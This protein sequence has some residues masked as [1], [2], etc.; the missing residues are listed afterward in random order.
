MQTPRPTWTTASKTA[1]EP[2][3]ALRPAVPDDY[4]FALALYIEG[5]AKH[6]KKIGRWDEARI[7]RRFARAF[8]LGVSHILRVDGE[9]AGWI[10]VIEF[11]GQLHLRQLHLAAFARNRGIG[12]HLIEALKARGAS[13]RKP[14][15]LDVMHGNPAKEL[16]LRLGFRPIRANLD[17]TRM[18]WR[19]E[20]AERKTAEAKS[21]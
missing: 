15:S 9:D 8:G 19:P 13:G 21:Q 5:S 12:T 7:L 3:Y 10:Q 18:I 6:L 20:R 2:V 16:Y 14:V 17:K 11:A 4:P 1:S